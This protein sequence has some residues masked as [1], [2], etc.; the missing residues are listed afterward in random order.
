MNDDIYQGIMS[1][2]VAQGYNAEK[3]KIFLQIKE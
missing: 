2:I 3:I 1:R